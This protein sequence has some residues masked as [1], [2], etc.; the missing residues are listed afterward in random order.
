MWRSWWHIS[1]GV[2]GHH[3]LF[4]YYTNAIHLKDDSASIQYPLLQPPTLHTILYNVLHFPS[5]I[6]TVING[7]TSF[8]SLPPTKG[9]LQL[10]VWWDNGGSYF[11][12][13]MPGADSNHFLFWRLNFD[14]LPLAFN[15]L[16]VKYSF[17]T[18]II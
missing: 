12:P 18:K 5:H 4:L 13:T 17:G 9:H 10:Q 3:H 16:L 6:K 2:W 8:S 7:I 11:Y 14:S 15:Q 1:T